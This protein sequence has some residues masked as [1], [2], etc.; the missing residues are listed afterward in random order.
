[1]RVFIVIAT[2]RWTILSQDV[3]LSTMTPRPLDTVRKPFRRR[4][5]PL[6]SPARHIAE[7][8]GTLHGYLDT[9]PETLL[10]L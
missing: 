8:M 10:K 2:S 3:P 5:G 6:S 1:M 4:H 7:C 9:K